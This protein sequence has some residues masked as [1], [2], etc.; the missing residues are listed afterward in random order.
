MKLGPVPLVA[1]GGAVGIVLWAGFNLLTGARE[2]WDHSLFGVA[3]ALSLACAA[4]LGGLASS[5]PWVGGVAVTFAMLPVMMLFSGS[6]SLIV[7]GIFLLGILSLPAAALAWAGWYLAK[8]LG[9]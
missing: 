3:Y 8:W 1:A 5:S 2:P 6:G 4:I 9:R 7:L